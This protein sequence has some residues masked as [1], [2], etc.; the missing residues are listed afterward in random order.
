MYAQETKADYI[1]AAA[2]HTCECIEGKMDD[3]S[4]PLEMKLGNCRVQ[5][6]S[7]DVA[8][9][10]KHF[11]ELNFADQQGMTRIGEQLGVAMMPIC[12]DVMMSL[13]EGAGGMV[14]SAEE[15]VQN[16]VSGRITKVGS[17][18]FVTLT[19]KTDNGPE[20]KLLWLDYFPG[21]ELLNVKASDISDQEF[22]FTYDT[23][24]LHNGKT[25]EYQSWRVIRS[26]TRK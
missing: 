7:N 1:N 26:V 25:G 14:E 24:D 18:T 8:R 11:G 13:V 15:P 22:R 2:N 21:E 9:Y 10:E 19:V 6:I 20:L 23:L 17:E 4:V 16:T 12:P 3:S 5:F